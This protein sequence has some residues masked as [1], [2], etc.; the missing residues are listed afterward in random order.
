MEV[1]PIP[2]EPSAAEEAIRAASPLVELMRAPYDDLIEIDLIH[3]RVKNLEHVE[4][5]YFLPVVTGTFDD[6]CRYSA[7][8]MIHPDDR[9]AYLAE[10]RLELPAKGDGNIHRVKM[11]YRLLGGGWRWVEQVNICGEKYGIPHGIA[12]SFLFDAETQEQSSAHTK[13]VGGIGSRKRSELTGLIRDKVFF[14]RGRELLRKHPHQ[15]PE[16]WCVLAIDVEHFKLFNDWYGRDQGDLLLAQIGARLTLVEQNSGGLACHIGQ[17]DFALLVPCDR[18]QISQL[19]TT[20]HD[21]VKSYGTSVGFMPSIGVA[22]IDPDSTDTMLEDYYDR[23]AT[24]ARHAKSDFHTRV[25]YFD[26]SMIEQ[27]EKDYL[28]L[29]DFQKA[30]ENHELFIQL[31]PQCRI[32][33]GKV[34]GAESLVRWRKANGEMVPPSEFVPVL[35]RNGFVTDLDKFVWE[36]VCA[37]QKHR[38]D[39]GHTPLPVSVNVSQ[40]DIFSIDVPDFFAHLLEK[41]ELPVDSIKIEITESAYVDNG[42]VAD[43]VRRLRA[44]GFLVLMDDFGSGYSSLNML[45]NLNVDVV[46]LDAQFLHLNDEDQ[47]KGIHILESV[48]NMVK[49]MGVPI[50]VEGV[51]TK[52]QSDFLAGL[53]CRY[54]Q[55]YYF[56]RPLPVDDFERLIDEPDQ[57][58]TRGLQYQTNEE[59]HFREFLDQNVYSD[60]MLNSILGAVA[61]YSWH[62]DEVDIMRYNQNFYDEVKI[63][64]FNEYTQSIQKM[65][66]PEDLPIL[67]GLFEKAI[68]DPLNGA[69]G[70]VRFRKPDG[71]ICQ[72]RM[73]FYF[74]GEDER[75]KRFYGSI[76]DLTEFITLNDHM[77]LLSQIFPDSVVFLRKKRGKW[78]S[79]VVIHGLREDMGLTAEEF[80]QELNSGNFFQ[81]LE[82]G[83]RDQLRQAAD[84]PKGLDQFTSPTR[85]STTSGIPLDV[86]VWFFGL[87]DKTSGVEYI[88]LL[89]KKNRPQQNEI[90]T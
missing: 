61:F 72:H 78:T 62:G 29:S 59:F 36:E 75:G 45:G 11:R 16:G 50:I 69:T 8:N 57:I 60:S 2:T 10:C 88:M 34:V 26:F 66:L 13:R 53:G 87:H 65:A 39:S 17:D 68:D 6:V 5:K 25:R 27:T 76:H 48:V 46:K 42:S 18:E 24:A 70:A 81:R 22:P 79:R 3:Q 7:E 51:E 47:K 82:P 19:Y 56:Y 49:T 64:G 80:E 32:S 12:Y 1:F 40:I 37:W 20:L 35:E 23:A 89:R 63:P 15:H 73:H 74:L 31:Q 71:T 33:T 38:I 41:Y 54:V 14:K 77:R 28:I 30:M 85:I 44:M 84:S 9:E 83:I 4:G 21:L 86:T 90:L 58:D 55:G 67:Y 52:E 43:A